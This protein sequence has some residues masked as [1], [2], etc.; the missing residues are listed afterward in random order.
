MRRANIVVTA[1]NLQRTTNNSQNID[2]PVVLPD[3]TSFTLTVNLPYIAS[4]ITERLTTTETRNTTQLPQSNQNTT[5]SK[6][7]IWD[8]NGNR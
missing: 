2:V 6:W 5:G 8:L 1:S 4:T 7:S 3:G